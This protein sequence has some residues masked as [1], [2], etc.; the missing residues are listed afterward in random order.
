MLEFFVDRKGGVTIDDCAA[1]S[2]ELSLVIDERFTDFMDFR[3]EVSSPGLDRPLKTGKDF[4]RHLGRDLKVD[5][6]LEG[7][8]NQTSGTLKS[9]SGTAIEL[10]EDK[11]TRIIPISSITR[12]KIELK[13]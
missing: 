9:V 1:I 2:R 11:G 3:L 12:A 7:K 6:T 8:H 13:W 5:W 4:M 10:L